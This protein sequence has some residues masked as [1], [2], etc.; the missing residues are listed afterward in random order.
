MD[1]MAKVKV[2]IVVSKVAEK[3]DYKGRVVSGWE[4]FSIEF[5]GE[6]ITKKR[7]W[8][9]WLDLPSDLVKDDVVEFTG[10]LGTKAA[11]FE[12]DGQIFKTVEH[13]INSPSFTVITRAVPL[14][15]DTW[16]KS[17]EQPF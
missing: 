8:T 15:M 6:Q 10:D 5:K 7:Q 14:P 2:Q 3:G 9:M 1:N 4:S 17:A 16:N 13:S 12:K 11:E